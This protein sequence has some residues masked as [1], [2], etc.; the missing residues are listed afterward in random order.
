MVAVL[1]AL[2]LVMP[3][4]SLPAPVAAD[5]L[6]ARGDGAAPA[7]RIVR[8][9]PT[10]TV[11]APLHDMR[12]SETVQIISGATLRSFPVDRIA[13]LVALKAGVIAQ[14]E[15]LHVRGGR[16]GDFRVFLSG[17]DLGDPVR[18]RAM[19]LPLLALSSAEV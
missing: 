4:D 13:D 18:G 17:V 12:S 15:E 19:E 8:Q 3:P 14:G 6:G 9:F 10:V 7:P 11:R 1:L 2:Q 5:S 16:A